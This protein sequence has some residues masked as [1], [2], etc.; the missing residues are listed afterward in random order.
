[1]MVSGQYEQRPR[2]M[3]PFRF[4]TPKKAATIPDGMPG[5][6]TW[7]STAVLLAN[8]SL[9]GAAAVMVRGGRPRLRQ[10]ARRRRHP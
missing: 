4:A 5:F 9:P 7:G 1:M 8:T 6:Q 10:A 3:P 2:M